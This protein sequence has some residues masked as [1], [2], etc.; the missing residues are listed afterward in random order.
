MGLTTNLKIISAET[1]LADSQLPAK[2]RN[3][4][5]QEQFDKFRQ[6]LLD[7]PNKAFL[8]LYSMNTLM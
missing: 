4:I 3:T 7:D 5:D 6:E 1:S 8:G 2:V